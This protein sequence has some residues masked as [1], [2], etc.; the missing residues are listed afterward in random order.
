MTLTSLLPTLRRSIPDP[1]AR[2]VWPVHTVA[3]RD[4]LVIGGVS[5]VRF[6][7]LCDTPAVMTAPAVIPLSGGVASLT[8]TTS[9]IAVRIVRV[10]RS[11]GAAALPT[12]V[13][14]GAFTACAPEWSHARVVGRI[15]VG[16]DRRFAVSEAA[17]RA[18]D[19]VT[20]LLPGDVTAGDVLA[21]PCVG[22]VSVGD[23]RPT[24]PARSVLG[25]A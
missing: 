12:L 10:E 2:D 3:A 22:A 15:C 17:G 8:A 23:V 6:V 9:V 1:L 16:A 20:L 25:A 11:D 21:V 7:A 13:L 18:V 14:D 4:D 19:A 5:L 24:E